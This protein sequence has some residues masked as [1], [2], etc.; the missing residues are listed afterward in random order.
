M[1]YC[2]MTVR[3]RTSIAEARWKRAVDVYELGYRNTVEIAAELS[4]S[5][6]TVSRE[7]KRRGARKACRVA[8]TV[9]DLEAALDAKA[10]REARRRAAKEAAALEHSAELDRLVE[11]LMRSVIAA[12]NSGNIAAASPKVAEIGKALGVKGLR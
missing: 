3:Q 1:L 12:S 2:G 8:E 5:R 6:S 7:F 11:E 9:V 4:V 10:R